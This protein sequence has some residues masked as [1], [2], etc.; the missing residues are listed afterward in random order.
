MRA[1]RPK[2]SQGRSLEQLGQELRDVLTTSLTPEEIVALFK[3]FRAM[4]PPI[5]DVGVRAAFRHGGD[6]EF[7]E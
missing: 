1:G 7:D 5:G 3:N 4:T 2:V 6:D